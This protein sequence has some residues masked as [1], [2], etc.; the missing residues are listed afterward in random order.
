MKKFLLR[1]T[2]SHGVY[3]EGQCESLILPTE[4]GDYG[5]LADHE[6]MVIAVKQG[7]LKY[8]IDEA[9]HEIYVGFGFC[10]TVK[11]HVYVVVDMCMKPEEVEAFKEHELLEEEQ[12]RMALKESRRLYYE[13]KLT[14]A[15]AMA[16]LKEEEKKY[17]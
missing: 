10:R 13:S 16:R 11:N 15:K 3:V 17:L 7:I 6:S 9:W 8:Q 2:E 5:I 1:I 12:E 4:D 14:M